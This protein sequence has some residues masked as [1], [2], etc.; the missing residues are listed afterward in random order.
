MFCRWS[1]TFAVDISSDS[2]GTVAPLVP[3]LLYTT[4]NYTLRWYDKN[5]IILIAPRRGLSS[6]FATGGVT[7][8]WY[9]RSLSRTGQ[10]DCFAFNG[11]YFGYGG[12]G[13]KFQPAGNA[14]ISL[15]WQSG[16]TVYSSTTDPDLDV[17]LGVDV[18]YNAIN[19]SLSFTASK[20]IRRG[21]RFF[22]WPMI[23]SGG[24]LNPILVESISHRSSRH[25]RT[26]MIRR[27]N[28]KAIFG[29]TTK[30]MTLSDLGS[31][32]QAILSTESI[33]VVNLDGGSSTSFWH[34]SYAFNPN[35]SIPSFFGMCER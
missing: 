3:D 4:K 18:S 17:N 26:F 24:I 14:T 9:A 16:T 10:T 2:S 21:V 22:A 31:R 28:G 35:K 15:W 30:K 23:V 6:V 32:L 1:T 8:S 20:T 5:A 27:A 25:Y 33:S 13:A 11:F 34:G 29:I 19:N 7:A 12:T